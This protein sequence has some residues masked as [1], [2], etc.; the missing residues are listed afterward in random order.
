MCPGGGARTDQQHRAD[1]GPDQHGPVHEAVRGEG[2]RAMVARSVT[3]G[4]V[5]GGG[6]S[7]IRLAGGNQRCL[8]AVK[9][10]LRENRVPGCPWAVSAGSSRCRIRPIGTRPARKS[11][12]V[13]RVIDVVGT[14]TTSWEEAA[15]NAIN[16][17]RQSVRDLR[18][19]R[20]SSG[21]SHR[22]RRRAHLPHEIQLSFEY[23]KE[24]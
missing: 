21:H 3:L 12:S 5:G 13:Y 16:T 6:R 10:P 20:S 11:T 9:Q 8:A 2:R 17:A 7:V 1:H 18:S 4:G 14:S 23:E 22:R 24:A 19:P 15:A